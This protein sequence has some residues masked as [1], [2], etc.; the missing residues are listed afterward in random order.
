MESGR[1][2]GPRPQDGKPTSQALASLTR[3]AVRGSPIHSP[4]VSVRVRYTGPTHVTLPA[5]NEHGIRHAH[6]GFTGVSMQRSVVLGLV[7]IAGL[8][9][10]AMTEQHVMVPMRDGVRLSV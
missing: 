6:A 7:A 8:N 5:Q 2:R 3:W 9:A 4:N 10:Q 1:G